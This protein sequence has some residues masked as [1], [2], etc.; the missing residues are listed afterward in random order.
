MRGQPSIVDHPH[1]RAGRFGMRSE[2][3]IG[4]PHRFT[5]CDAMTGEV[6]A[7]KFVPGGL[8]SPIEIDEQHARHHGGACYP[9]RERHGMLAPRYGLRQCPDRHGTHRTRSK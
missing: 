5:L 6:G 9:Y 8:A 3:A 7:R 2:R 4:K 1:A